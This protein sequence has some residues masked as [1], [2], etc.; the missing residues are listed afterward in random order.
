MYTGP[1]FPEI[2]AGRAI[3]PPPLRGHNFITG[4]SAWSLVFS[5]ALHAFH[6]GSKTPRSIRQAWHGTTCNRHLEGS[7]IL[8]AKMGA[9]A[10][11][12]VA[13]HW[14]AAARDEDFLQWTPSMTNSVEHEI[15]FVTSCFTMGLV[16]IL[17]RTLCE[18]S[19][20]AKTFS[21]W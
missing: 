2:R 14:A 1:S 16:R 5:I 20:S 6:R 12:P 13:A 19:N 21:R 9:L 15:A 4:Q 11:T 8:T 3:L 10:A 7:I 18:M 17:P